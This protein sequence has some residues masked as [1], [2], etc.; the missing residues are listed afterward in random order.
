MRRLG[1]T[2]SAVCFLA[3]ELVKAGVACTFFNKIETPQSAHSITS[4]PLQ[5]L[6]DEAANPTYTAFIFCGRWVEWLVAMVR[7]KTSVPIIAWMHESVL[8]TNFTPAL[9]AFNGAVF[10]SQWQA[11]TNRALV[12]PQWRTTIIRNA[13]NPVF[14][15]G[16]AVKKQPPLL[17]ICRSN[18]AR[19]V[20][21]ARDT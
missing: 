18:A 21:H 3:R 13:M 8:G 14:A 7:E 15:S 11:D 9:G 2:N 17:G 10:V 5:S 1:G 19:C 6:I 4:L 12:P 20:A 16:E